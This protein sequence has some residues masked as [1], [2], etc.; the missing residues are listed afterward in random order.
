MSDRFYDLKYNFPRRWR[1][2]AYTRT[3]IANDNVFSNVKSRLE[4]LN[5][6]L[7]L[8]PEY[9][10]LAKES[11]ADPYEVDVNVVDKIKNA[12]AAINR[13][14]EAVESLADNNQ[15]GAQQTIIQQLGVPQRIDAV[16]NAI[17]A[18]IDLYRDGIDPKLLETLYVKADLMFWV[19][20]VQELG[21]IER[22]EK[23]ATK[24]LLN[25]LLH[26]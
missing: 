1:R 3:V 24:K 2:K 20:K 16:K 19:K 6:Q 25:K 8:N 9:S 17:V 4:R 26:K 5:S 12:A 14:I 22:M 11:I 23:E 10:L 13:A 15:E 21:R 7:R 18:I